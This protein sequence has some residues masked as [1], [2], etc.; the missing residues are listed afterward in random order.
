MRGHVGIRDLKQRTSALLRLVRER[1]ESID[2]SYRGEIVA[3]I[4]PV[5]KPAASAARARKVWRDI[6][7]VAEEIS[8]HWPRGVGAVR[9]LREARR[10]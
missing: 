7:R 5:A 1:G 2:I 9:A 6:D 4:V 10:G 8:K 3:R